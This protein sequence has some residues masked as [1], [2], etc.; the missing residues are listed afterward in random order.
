MLLS[1][2]DLLPDLAPLTLQDTAGAVVSLSGLSGANLT[3]ILRNRSTDQ[4]T[5]GAGSFTITDAANGIV[6][7]AFAAPDTAVAGQFDIRVRA[8][9]SGKPRTFRMGFLEV[10]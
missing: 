8:I 1:V 10:E 2:G 7:Y 9:F 4:I 3:L 5:T 6:R